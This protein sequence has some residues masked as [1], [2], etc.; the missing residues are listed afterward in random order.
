MEKLE[1]IQL[2]H[3]R[4]AQAYLSQALLF[5]T[6]YDN[7]YLF[8]QFAVTH[9]ILALVDQVDRLLEYLQATADDAQR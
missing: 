3:R 7:E 1:E 5:S 6:D 4:E 2:D 9:S 8:T